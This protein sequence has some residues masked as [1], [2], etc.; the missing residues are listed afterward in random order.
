M[1][2]SNISSYENGTTE[3]VPA[4]YIA[5][6]VRAG[7]NP[8]WLLG[9]VDGPKERMGAEERDTHAHA[10]R[11]RYIKAY[12]FDVEGVIGDAA[13]GREKLPESQ[14]D[15]GSPSATPPAGSDR[16]DSESDTE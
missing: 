16:L 1:S 9:L 15:S 13:E 14:Q 10:E 11:Y 5:A 4:D 8:E 2:R 6:W 7:F 3:T 12:V